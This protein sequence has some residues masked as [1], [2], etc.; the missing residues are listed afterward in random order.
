MRSATTRLPRF[1]RRQAV[2][3]KAGHVHAP[4]RV[5]AVDDLELVA[6]ADVVVHRVVAGR[7]L[8]RAGAEVLLDGLIADDGQP[9]SDQ[10]Q[11]RGLSDQAL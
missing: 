1:E 4:V 7:D 2:V 9:A 5:H 10:R 3:G 6:L 8:Q 11:D